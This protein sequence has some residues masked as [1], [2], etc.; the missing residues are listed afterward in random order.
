MTTEA[1]LVTISI[2][3]FQRGLRI[4]MVPRLLLHWRTLVSLAAPVLLCPLLFAI[5][6]PE[7]R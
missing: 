1:V 2:F 6:T 5:N 3:L 4:R 7:A